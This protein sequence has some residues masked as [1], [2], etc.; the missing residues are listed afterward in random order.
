MINDSE[1]RAFYSKAYSTSWVRPDETKD[2]H[3]FTKMWYKSFLRHVLPRFDWRGKRVLEIGAGYGYLAPA[4]CERGAIY[5]GTEIVRSAISQFEKITNCHALLADGCKLPFP[6][7]SFDYVICMEVVEHLQNPIPLIQEAIRVS[8]GALIFSCPNYFNLFGPI[9]LLA[10]I[11]IPAARQY[12]NH[13]IV[14]R[15]T[16]SFELRRM[17][18]ARSKIVMQRAVRLA[19]PLLEK[20]DWRGYGR[21]NDCWFWIEDH[22]SQLPPFNFLGLHTLCVAEKSRPTSATATTAHYPA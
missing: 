10:N 13:Q 8:R 20:L 6:E 22:L 12:L 1:V 14:D 18:S 3:R 2:G 16:T 4:L 15:T 11:G 19:P 5:V 17:L 9:K 7:E 21:A